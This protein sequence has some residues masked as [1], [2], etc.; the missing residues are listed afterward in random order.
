MLFAVCLVWRHAQLFDGKG[1]EAMGR[2]VS[3][4]RLPPAGLLGRELL[5]SAVSRDI[6]KGLFRKILI[7]ELSY[8]KII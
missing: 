8:I 7:A 4:S 2:D 6:I 1:F 5:L 3:R